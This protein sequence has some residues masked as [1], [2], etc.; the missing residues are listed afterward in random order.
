MACASGNRRLVWPAD[1]SGTDALC[2]GAQ[3]SRTMR[4]GVVSNVVHYAPRE[5]LHAYG[6]YARELDIW[7]DLFEEVTILGPCRNTRPP[8]DAVAFTRRNIKIVPQKEC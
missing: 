7:A 5:G 6:P 8:G 2:G 3:G 4:L 1:R